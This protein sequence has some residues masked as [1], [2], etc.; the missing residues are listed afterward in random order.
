MHDLGIANWVRVPQS[1]GNAR[2]FH[3]AWRLVALI[4]YDLRSSSF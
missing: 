4:N 2:E 1:R 3:S